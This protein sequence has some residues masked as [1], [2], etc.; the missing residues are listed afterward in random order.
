MVKRIG[1]MS[2][3]LINRL[4][5]NRKKRNLK[6]SSDFFLKIILDQKYFFVF[7]FFLSSSRDSGESISSGLE[8]FPTIQTLQ[9]PTIFF[10]FFDGYGSHLRSDNDIIEDSDLRV[11]L[12][13][14]TTTSK[15]SRF[16][17]VLGSL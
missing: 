3:S 11:R 17:R 15:W 7:D 6:K 8:A 5:F 9:F 12:R 14:G 10:E 1:K 2:I 13:G 16:W 4:K